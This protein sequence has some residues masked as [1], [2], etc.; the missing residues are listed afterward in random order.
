MVIA[1]ITGLSNSC[2][3]TAATPGS[4]S[5]TLSGGTIPR[6]GICTLRVDV[7]APIAG[8]YTNNSG[9]ITATNAA[10][11]SSAAALLQVNIPN[12]SVFKSASTSTTDPGQEVAYTITIRN[13]NPFVINNVAV[14]DSMSPYTA[15]KLG[16]FVITDGTPVSGLNL[17][18]VVFSY[19]DNYG[20]TWSYVPVSGQGG[21]PAGY[22]GA[23]SSWKIDMGPAGVMNSNNASLSIQYSVRVR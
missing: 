3:G 22:D 17:G 18:S 16:S 23:V 5:L 13:P 14:V 2:G 19:S 8:S 20:S 10:N 21:Q 9:S 7:S 12:I 6:N 11:G 15:L 1:T 4:N